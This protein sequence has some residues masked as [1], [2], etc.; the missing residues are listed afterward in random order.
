MHS[1]HLRQ[2]L[3]VLTVIGAGLF[4]TNSARPSTGTV[5]AGQSV[6]FSVSA[7]GTA[8]FAYQWYKNGAMIAGATGGTFSIGSVAET[9]AGN[10]YAFV[11]NSA[12]STTSDDATLIVNAATVAPAF[13]TQPTSQTVPAG[14]AVSFT[15]AAGGTPAPTYQWRKNG[16]NLTGATSASYTI[17][18]VAMGDAGTY[19]VVATNSAGAVTSNGAV[20]TVNAATVVPAFTTQPTS[21]TVSCL[22]YTSPSPRDR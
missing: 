1:L 13:T 7:D 5:L 20:L 4:I 19:T 14:A 9:D 21:Q 3:A 22:L 16:A 18:S 2:A 6:T 10:Y 17:A 15:A 8:P 12:G 11:S